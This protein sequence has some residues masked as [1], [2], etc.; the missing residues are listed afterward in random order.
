MFARGTIKKKKEVGLKIH[1][2][3]LL[4]TPLKTS[5]GINSKDNYK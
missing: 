1:L 4:Y 3:S 5:R 2:I